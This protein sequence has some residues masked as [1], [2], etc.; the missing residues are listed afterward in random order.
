MKSRRGVM[1]CKQHNEGRLTG[2]VP[3]CVGTAYC[4]T[5]SKGRWREGQGLWE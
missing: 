5:L 4:N 2:L 1:F 3:F